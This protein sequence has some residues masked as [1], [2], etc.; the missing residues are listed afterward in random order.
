MG[1]SVPTTWVRRPRTTKPK[2]KELQLHPDSW[3]GFDLDGT[4]AVYPHS[5]PEIGPPVP[6]M[7]ARLRQLLDAG[8]RCKIFTGRVCLAP[9]EI[10]S[11]EDQSFQW[12]VDEQRNRVETWCKEYV[13]RVLEVTA[14]KDLRMIALFDDRAIAVETNTGQLL[15]G[16]VK[17]AGLTFI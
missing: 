14:E 16:K 2:E 12:F 15:Q 13:G 3:V 17:I 5:F 7:L 11:Y 9:K 4:L 1:E 6:I 8:I 10:G